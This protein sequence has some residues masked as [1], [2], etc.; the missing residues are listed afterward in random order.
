MTTRRWVLL[1]LALVVI[2][3]VALFRRVHVLRAADCVD[4]HATRDS[5]T[6][7]IRGSMMHS[8]LGAGASTVERDGARVV[9]R[10]YLVPAGSGARRDFVVPVTLSDDVREVWFGDLPGELTCG[11]IAGIPLRIPVR[12]PSDAGVRVWSR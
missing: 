4:L 3:V 6:V 1:L 7:L 9:V 2:A 12:S 10:V 11:R 5:Q 8:G